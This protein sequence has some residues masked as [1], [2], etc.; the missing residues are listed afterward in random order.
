[1]SGPVHVVLDPKTMLGEWEYSRTIDDRV[2]G[3]QLTAA[4]RAVLERDGAAIRWR[5]DGV[6][7][8]DDGE[9]PVTRTLR[10]RQHDG[11]G[12]DEPLWSVEFDDGRPFHDWAVDA[13]LVHQCGADTYRG[14]IS[15]GHDRWSMTWEVVGPSKDYRL[16]TH[17]WRRDASDRPDGCAEGS[18]LDRRR[19]R[20]C[21]SRRAG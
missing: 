16:V 20:R 9:V 18:E 11:S 3:A 8:R 12:I 10:M 19:N 17:Y 1:M 6:L 2:Q 7:R 15:A 4:G 13:A 21:R 14:A 5:E